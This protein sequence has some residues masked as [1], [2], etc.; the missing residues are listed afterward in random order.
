MLLL[1]V[2]VVAAAALQCVSVWRI[3]TAS[4][5]RWREW[6]A[7]VSGRPVEVLAILKLSDDGWARVLALEVLRLC[8]RSIHIERPACQILSALVA[9]ALCDA[10][11]GIGLMVGVAA[12]VMPAFPLDAEDEEER[13]VVMR[14]RMRIMMWMN[15]A[16][17]CPP[18]QERECAALGI[19]GYIIACPMMLFIACY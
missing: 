12:V 10:W 11:D 17:F 2:D 1:L 4:L 19:L 15:G 5:P 6:A 16:F 14:I 13:D 7:V 9:V 3:L 18:V 8:C